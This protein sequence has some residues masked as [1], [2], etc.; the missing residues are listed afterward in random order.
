MYKPNS[1]FVQW[2]HWHTLMVDFSTFKL[3]TLYFNSTCK[4]N[5]SLVILIISVSELCIGLSLVIRLSKFK[6]G[7][8]KSYLNKMNF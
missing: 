7:L 3:F 6:G 8:K 4:F 2:I 5:N 1:H